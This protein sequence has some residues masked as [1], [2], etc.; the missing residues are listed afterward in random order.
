VGGRLILGGLVK[1]HRK[2]TV[3][4]IV[5]VKQPIS[6]EALKAMI[7]DGLARMIAIRIFPSVSAKPGTPTRNAQ[8]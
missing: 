6:R 1:K 8:K 7:C 5:N 2:K 4:V 3:G